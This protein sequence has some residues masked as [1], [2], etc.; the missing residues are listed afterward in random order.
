M[1][2]NRKRDVLVWEEYEK[3]RLG[4]EWGAKGMFGHPAF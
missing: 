3:K 1:K 4:K 2:G